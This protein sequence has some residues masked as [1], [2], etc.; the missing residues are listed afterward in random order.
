MS[1]DRLSHLPILHIHKDVTFVEL[2]LLNDE[3]QRIIGLLC[4]MWC[5]CEFHHP[6]DIWNQTDIGFMGAVV[7][8]RRYTSLTY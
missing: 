3:L 4:I 2:V 6:S 1:Q 5:L 7:K 8:Y